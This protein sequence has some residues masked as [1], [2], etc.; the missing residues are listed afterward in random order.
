MIA[1]LTVPVPGDAIRIAAECTR[2]SP[3]KTR[4]VRNPF[5]EIDESGG[6]FGHFRES[7][8]RKGLHKAQLLGLQVDFGAC[9]PYFVHL[10]TLILLFF[11]PLLLD[12]EAFCETKPFS[13]LRLSFLRL[14]SSFAARS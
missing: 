7:R 4:A 1:D 9:V 2:E 8:S 6:H 13:A 3:T 5:K 14:A 10:V 12:L 11:A